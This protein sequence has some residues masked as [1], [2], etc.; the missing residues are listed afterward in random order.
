MLKALY[1]MLVYSFFNCK[2]LR[3][4]IE[5][6]LFEMNQYDICVANLMNYGKQQT[7]DWYIDDL[8]SS[9]VNPKVDE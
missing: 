3:K 4:N 9:H 2:T 6:I 1:G 8:K 7:V 5:A